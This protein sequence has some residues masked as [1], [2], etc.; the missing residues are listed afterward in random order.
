MNM[1]LARWYPVY[2]REELVVIQLNCL[3]DLDSD[4]DWKKS[5]AKEVQQ[6]LNEYE[7]AVERSKKGRV[8]PKFSEIYYYNNSSLFKAEA[9]NV[10]EFMEKFRA[11]LKKD[12]ERHI[13]WE[14][15]NE[16]FE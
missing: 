11:E 5:N 10:F 1:Y 6:R 16:V 12:H 2:P 8:V 13:E 15:S 9:N 3:D 4:I 7:W 14:S